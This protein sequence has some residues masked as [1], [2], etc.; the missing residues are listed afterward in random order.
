MPK[1]TLVAYSIAQQAG[2]SNAEQETQALGRRLAEL[3]AQKRQAEGL[4]PGPIR[5][6]AIAEAEQAM[7]EVQQQ[8]IH[9]P[10]RFPSPSDTCV[11][12]G[13]AH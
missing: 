1:A 6:R 10:L 9:R 11:A 4:L 3:D 13:S 12:A 2:K 8:A 7:Q 5:D